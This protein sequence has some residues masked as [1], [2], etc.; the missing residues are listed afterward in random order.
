MRKKISEKKLPWT[1]DS[2]GTANYHVNESPDPRA[3]TAARSYGVDISE[4]RGRQFGVKDFEHFDRIYV[5]D[6]SNY[7][8]VIRLARNQSDK[9]KVFHFLV[10][11][12][13]GM[14]VPDPWFGE[15]EGFFPVY[16]MLNE[17]CEGIIEEFLGL[18]HKRSEIKNR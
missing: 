9:E 16:D 8:N 14:D 2:A 4:L 7:K 17:R 6:T 1:V 13:S 15:P 5:M 12:K 3:I 11:G 10:D 18:E